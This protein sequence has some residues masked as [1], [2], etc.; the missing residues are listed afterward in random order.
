MKQFGK[1][2]SNLI[3]SIVNKFKWKQYCHINIYE[4]IILPQSVEK[5]VQNEHAVQLF[6]IIF[7]I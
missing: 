4:I 2:G 5:K 6:A 3:L 1:T 7:T